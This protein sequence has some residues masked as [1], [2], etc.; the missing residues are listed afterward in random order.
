[1]GDQHVLQGRA[2]RPRKGH[3]VRGLCMAEWLSFRCRPLLSQM[4]PRPLVCLRLSKTHAHCSAPGPF[5]LPPYA[6]QRLCTLSS[7]ALHCRCSEEHTSNVALDNTHAPSHF[8]AHCIWRPA[9]NL[10]HALIPLHFPAGAWR[11]ISVPPLTIQPTA[12]GAQLQIDHTLPF[13]CTPLQVPGGAHRQHRHV[14]G[15]QR[16][17]EGQAG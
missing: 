13:L 2:S 10:Q 6:N 12:S 5:C 8:P 16:R 3:Q 7:C 1:M 11:T 9:S 14:Q 17:G 15:V 4:T